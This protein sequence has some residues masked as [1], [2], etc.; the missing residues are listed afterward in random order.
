MRQFRTRLFCTVLTLLCT[1]VVSAENRKAAKDKQSPIKVET[2]KNGTS[3]RREAKAALKILPLNRL[4]PAQQTEVN[5]ILKKVSHFRK[6][7]ELRFEV[8]PGVY[9]YFGKNPDAAVSI[10]RVMEISKFKMHRV[11]AGEFDADAGDGSTGHASVLMQTPTE[12]LAVCDGVYKNSLLRK[13]IKARGVMHL[14]TKYQMNNQRQ[15]FVTHNLNVW[16]SFPSTTI[17]T[18]ARV[19][20]PLTNMIMDRNFEEVSVFLQMMTLAMERQP[21]WVERMARRMTDVNQQQRM[22]L[23]DLTYEVNNRGMQRYGISR[24][25]N[26]QLTVD[27]L[28]APL[29]N[30]SPGSL[31]PLSRVQI[32]NASQ[33]GKVPIRSAVQSQGTESGETK[34]GDTDTKK[35]AVGKVRIK[36]A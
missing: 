32:R 3:S 20:S 35:I 14:Q 18:A 31:Q 5:S 28:M 21:T 29:K 25:S 30:I 16:V 11:S 17:R 7:P 26:S 9:Q 13:P 2:L 24:N 23:L 27:E 22:Q 33:H 36:D 8:D 12:T 1:S 34:S 4:T 10:W 19:L 15:T 6:L